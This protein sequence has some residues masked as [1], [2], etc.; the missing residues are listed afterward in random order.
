MGLG[1]MNTIKKPSRLFILMYSLITQY[2]KRNLVREG[3]VHCLE[4]SDFF[5]FLKNFLSAGF[6]FFQKI[7]SDQQHR[8][9][10]FRQRL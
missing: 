8:I 6:S 7:P 1:D 3:A 2:N 10:S 5:F 4:L 9:S